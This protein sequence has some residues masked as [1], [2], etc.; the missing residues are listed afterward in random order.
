[1]KQAFDNNSLLGFLH[2]FYYKAFRRSGG[3]IVGIA[4]GYGLVD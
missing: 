1:L 2:Y 4:T 3:S